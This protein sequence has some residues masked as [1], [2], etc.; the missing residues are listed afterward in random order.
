MMPIFQ[1]TA[2][3]SKE[4]TNPLA[5]D[6]ARRI[7]ANIASCRKLIGVLRLFVSYCLK[8]VSSLLI[9]AP[10]IDLHARQGNYSAPVLGIKLYISLLCRWRP[11]AK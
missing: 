6:K 1:P 3:C 5:H 11:R 8:D 9:G 4:H 7:A 10:G 2:R